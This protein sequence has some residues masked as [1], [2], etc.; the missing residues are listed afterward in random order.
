MI[1][2][3]RLP[4]YKY[5]QNDINIHRRVVAPAA[6]PAAARAAAVRACV[7]RIV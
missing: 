7:D 2:K 5:Y 6:A 4:E 1:L 3:R